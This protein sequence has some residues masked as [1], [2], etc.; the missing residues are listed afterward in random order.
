MYCCLMKQP[1]FS[2]IFI[3]K[4]GGNSMSENRRHMGKIKKDVIIPVAPSLSEMNNSYIDFINDLKES[5]K[6]ERIK[7]VFAANKEMIIL[8]WNIG[9]KILEKQIIEG[10]GAKVIDRLSK[11]LN[12]AFP[13]MRGFSSRN[14]KYMRKFA[15]CWP[16]F[17]LVQ[18]CVALI[19]GGKCILKLEIKTFTSICYSII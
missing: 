3:I 7:I 13:E 19:P 4:H 15:E 12:E 1:N 8:Y 5:I 2:K 17:E 6:K 18:R 16:D 10:W 9:K 11:D 14:L